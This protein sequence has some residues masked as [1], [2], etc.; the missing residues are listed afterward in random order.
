MKY[1]SLWIDAKDLD[2]L[3]SRIKE[4]AG[5]AKSGPHAVLA[6]GS[7]VEQIDFISEKGEIKARLIAHYVDHHYAATKDLPEDV[8]DSELIEVLVR[9]EA[10]KRWR[11]PVE[12]VYVEAVEEIARELEGYS[13][14]Y[15]CDE[16]RESVEHYQRRSSGSLLKRITGS[17]T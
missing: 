11:A 3:V 15:P 5:E 7:E 8:S 10:S 12:P 1:K 14:D 17:A 6:D 16:A 9:A 4:L 2:K 13:D